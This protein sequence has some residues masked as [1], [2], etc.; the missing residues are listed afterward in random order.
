M[1]RRYR[2]A[3]PEV[4][5]TA[6]C[7]FDETDEEDAP[8]GGL[9]TRTLFDSPGGHPISSE[10]LASFLVPALR[11]YCHPCGGS[12]F[13]LARAGPRADGEQS[14]EALEICQINQRKLARFIEGLELLRNP[15]C[16][17]WH[18]EGEGFQNPACDTKVMRR[19]V[20][21]V[22]WAVTGKVVRPEWQIAGMDNG[23]R[24]MKARLGL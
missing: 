17:F 15:R 14:P 6:G 20:D 16:V 24:R 3:L 21:R 12:S 8:D 11:R 19:V 22:L 9:V 1:Y 4:Y 23:L 5:A 18:L 7:I 2:G 13:L 10:D